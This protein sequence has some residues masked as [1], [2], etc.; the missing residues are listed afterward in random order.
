M[1][2]YKTGGKI[3]GDILIDGKSKDPLIWKKIC[4]Y[5]EQQ[6]ILNPY[7]SVLETL[8]FT[9]T[10]RLPMGQN[11]EEVIQ[12][13]LKLMDIE[14]WNAHIIGRELDGEGLPKHVRK[15]VTIANELVAL[16]RVSLFKVAISHQYG[17]SYQAHL[18]PWHHIRG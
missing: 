1:A 16:P 13:V 5:A 7:L 8:R 2:G 9:A 18:L 14:E 6:D 11:R 12:R 10:C 17:E 4:G 3:T 15:R